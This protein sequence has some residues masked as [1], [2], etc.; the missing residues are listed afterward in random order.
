MLQ[1]VFAAVLVITDVGLTVTT[2]LNGV[3][4][5]PPILGVIIY[6]T[7]TGAMTVLTRDSLISAV[8][9]APAKLEIPA[10]TALVQANV[11]PAV[12][13][14]AV[15]PRGVL[16]QIF[17][18]AALVIT[19]VGLTVTVRV[20][21]VPL[22]PFMPGVMIYIAFT[23]AVVVLV[24]DSLISAVAP[25]PAT[26]DIPATTARVHEN[27]APTVELVAV[28]PNGVVL[29]TVGAA[30]L[31]ITDVGLTTTVLVIGAPIQAVAPGPLGVI[32]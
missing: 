10:T 13:E 8:A 16:L 27:E 15:Y 32:V 24:R 22:H 7:A 9:P 28:Y 25:A 4:A 18:V 30:A 6:V 1:T 21:G 5:H 29:Q 2:R 19:A 17:A 12:D 20:N 14:V 31:V 3:P 23:G 11:A 26:L